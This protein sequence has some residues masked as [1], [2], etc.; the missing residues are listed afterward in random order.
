MLLAFLLLANDSPPDSI[1][2][3]KCLN[4]PLNF[5]SFFPTSF[6][7]PEKPS[8]IGKPVFGFLS[9]PS[10]PSIFD[11]WASNTSFFEGS[12]RSGS[13]TSRLWPAHRILRHTVHGDGLCILCT[14]FAGDRHQNCVRTCRSLHKQSRINR[15]G[16]CHH[17]H[18]SM[19]GLALVLVLIDNASCFLGRLLIES[20]CVLLEWS[21]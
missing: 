6:Y 3:C 7:I 19:G 9:G 18:A 14:Q 13:G 2:N 20:L 1:P 16:C 5:L 11:K 8:P 4:Y 10:S 17:E 15:L 12:A 21:H